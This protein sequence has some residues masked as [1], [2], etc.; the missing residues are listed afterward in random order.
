MRRKTI[1]LFTNDLEVDYAIHI[2]NGV[3][4]RCIELDINFI[5]IVGSELRQTTSDKAVHTKIDRNKIY[6]LASQMDLDGILISAPVLYHITDEQ[7]SEFISSFNKT[8]IILLNCEAPNVS[9]VLV[10]GYVGMRSAVEHLIDVHQAKRILFFRGPSTS[11]EAEQRYQAYT[12]VLAERNIRLDPN[13]VLLSDFG[14][15]AVPNLL[16]QYIDR[17]GVT[18]DAAIGSNDLIALSVLNALPNLHGLS[19]PKDIKVIGFDNTSRGQFTT[20][21]LSSV[22]QP[23]MG[24]ATRG[25]DLLTELMSGQTI[26][27]Q[28]ILP[29]EL[30]IRHSC[31][32]LNVSLVNTDNRFKKMCDAHLDWLDSSSSSRSDSPFIRQ[33]YQLTY[34]TDDNHNSAQ[35]EIAEF[36]QL[37]NIYVEMLN[38]SNGKYE[39]ELAISKQKLQESLYSII[40]KNSTYSTPSHTMDWDLLLLALTTS[41]QERAQDIQSVLRMNEVYRSTQEFI[42]ELT[43]NQAAAIEARKFYYQSSVSYIGQLLNGPFDLPSLRSFLVDNLPQLHINDFSIALYEDFAN[44]YSKQEEKQTIDKTDLP[45]DD[46]D[47]QIQSAH[48]FVTVNNRKE[49]TNVRGQIF[50]RSQILPNGLPEEEEPLCLALLP[51][52][53]SS[54]EI[55][56]GVFSIT[57]QNYFSCEPMHGLIERVLSTIYI[58]TKLR[59]AESQA[60][61]AN[62]AKGSF[63]ANMSHEIR[64]PMNGVLGMARLLAATALTAEQ[65]ELVGIISQSGESLLTIINEILD[66]SKLEMAGVTLEH[67]P[68]DLYDCV[69]QVVDLLAPT[70]TQ[71]GLYLCLY[72][73]Q[74][75]PQYYYGD[76]ARLRQIFINL[77][78]NAIKFTETGGVLFKVEGGT[79]NHSLEKNLPIHF[80]VIDTGIGIPK[81]AQAKLFRDFTQA[82]ES[83]T[84]KYGGT[85]LGLVISKKLLVQMGGTIEIES[86]GEGGSTFHANALLQPNQHQPNQHHIG[87]RQ[88][89]PAIWQNKRILIAEEHAIVRET[90]EH[91]T[92]AWQMQPTI[93]NSAQ[94]IDSTIKSG[95]T[96]DLILVSEQLARC[97]VGEK[98]LL[99]TLRHQVSSN[100]GKVLLLSQFDSQ[101]Q[102]DNSNLSFASLIYKPIKP[103]ELYNTISNILTGKA[104][105]TSLKSSAENQ[106]ENLA[107]NHPKNILLVEDNVVNQKV[108]RRMLEQLGYNA[109]LATDGLEAVEAVA[110]NS[111]DIVFM[112]VQMP[113]MNGL[114]ATR[115]IREMTLPAQPTIVA[116]SAS[117]MVEDHTSALEAGMN[118]FVDKPISLKELVR[119]LTQRTSN[120]KS[121]STE[122]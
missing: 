52:S 108:A 90:L 51:F 78:G 82:D 26:P 53:D 109:D 98:S 37:I 75:I 36:S 32:C 115:R 4:Q 86:S 76:A 89:T 71:K 5:S 102:A 3:R 100:K 119:V 8:P 6:A 31:G 74:D 40:F 2:W 57:P 94:A 121:I 39:K 116:M 61:E 41:I 87:H 105:Q 28:S 45:I 88:A 73:D 91:Y 34:R 69:G 9:S 97:K 48:C 81:A 111:Y 17:F 27:K 70:A 60:Q 79:T 12:D 29:A 1:A 46:S 67:E 122:N 103:V 62:L 68:F 72:I 33:L 44:L 77:V 25:V 22:S 55:G 101:W 96:Y 107:L 56:Y 84:R 23:I 10:D 42:I 18:F 14:A 120:T 114:D 80:R 58:L 99:E 117:A 13:L 20:P 104:E 66:Y 118:D 7:I 63:L 95:A 30:V 93:L 16:Q 112:D 21:T 59:E 54:G 64:T 43:V 47:P 19:V 65:E 92:N 50:R 24:I 38:P 35:A 106:I 11:Y 83:T 113:K 49:K 15:H 85:G 110:K